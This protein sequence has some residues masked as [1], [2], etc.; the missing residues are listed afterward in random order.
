M[1][2]DLVLE[3]KIEHTEPLHIEV[4]RGMRGQYGWKIGVYGGCY[5]SMVVDIKDADQKLRE[6]F[7]PKVEE[8]TI[9]S[10]EH[11]D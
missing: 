3:H 8:V 1:D 4:E 9:E 11:T 5:A 7:L 6:L 10:K 2:I